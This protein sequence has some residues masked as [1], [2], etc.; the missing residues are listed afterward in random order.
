MVVNS[1]TNHQ[2]PNPQSEG[3][4]P[5]SEGGTPAATKPTVRKIPLNAK[6]AWIKAAIK[7]VLEGPRL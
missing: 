4:T 5:Q 7:Y 3:A 6:D 2:N 1:K